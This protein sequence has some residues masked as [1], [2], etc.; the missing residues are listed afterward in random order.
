LGF[1]LAPAWALLA[2]PLWATSLGVAWSDRA[3]E[4]PGLPVAGAVM[5]EAFASPAAPLLEVCAKAGHATS[6]DAATRVKDKVRILVPIG[7]V[8][9]AKTTFLARACATVS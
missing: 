5:V 7:M 9:V 3:A 6:M 4:V 8:G 1:S 2:A